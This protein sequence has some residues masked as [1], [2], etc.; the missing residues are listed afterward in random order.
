MMMM[1]TTT[2][3]GMNRITSHRIEYDPMVLFDVFVST[4]SAKEFA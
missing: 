3:L 2:T 4:S 1:T